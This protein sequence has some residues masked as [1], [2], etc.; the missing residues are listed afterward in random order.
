MKHIIR[1]GDNYSVPK[2][3]DNFL[4]GHTK[5]QFLKLFTFKKTIRYVIETDSNILYTH[6]NKEDQIRTNKLFGIS[7][8][9]HHH[10]DS[11]RLG[12]FYWANRVWI[13]AYIYNSGEHRIEHLYNYEPSENGFYHTGMIEIKKDTYRIV[14][15]MGGFDVTTKRTSR[16]PLWM[17]RK[18]LYP[19]FGKKGLSAIRDLVF[20]I[21]IR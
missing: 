5:E 10:K 4:F 19:Y 13:V 3:F 21:Y 18:Y 17:P 8:H 2:M 9:V 15:A 14:D 6:D 1:K 7:D 20:S 11:I 16:Y 12:Y